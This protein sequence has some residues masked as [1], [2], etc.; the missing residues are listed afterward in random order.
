MPRSKI[1]LIDNETDEPFSRLERVDHF[2]RQI[3]RDDERLSV[4]HTCGVFAS[5]V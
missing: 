4:N 5:R 1:Q 2:T 3:R